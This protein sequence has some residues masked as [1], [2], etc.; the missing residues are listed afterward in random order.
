MAESARQRADDSK[1]EIFPKPQGS[2]VG[3]D[4]EVEL[5]RSKTETREL[6]A[7][8]AQPSLARF[9]DLGQMAKP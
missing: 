9:R 8:N 7:D 3:S 6:R 2:F 1:S 5:H 4:D